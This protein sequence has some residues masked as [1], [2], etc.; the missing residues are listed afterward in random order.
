M[1][2]MMLHAFFIL[3]FISVSSFKSF[4]I[5]LPRYLNS[6]TKW[7]RF[8]LLL[9]L[10]SGRM[11]FVLFCSFVSLSMAGKYM[12]TDFDFS[13]AVPTCILR[14]NFAKWLKRAWARLV[15]LSRVVHTE[16][17]SSTYRRLSI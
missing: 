7:M 13:V 5:I 1:A 12:A 11:L 3:A 14:P 8:V 4:D 9:S 2:P 10:M 6:W 17:P 15:R 16:A